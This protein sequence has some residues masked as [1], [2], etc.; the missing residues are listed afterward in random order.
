MRSRK[1]LTISFTIPVP[2]IVSTNDMYFHRPKKSKKGNRITTYTVKTGQLKE[3]QE[4]MDLE[5]KSTLEYYK[6]TIEE[7]RDI[8]SHGYHGLVIV[9]EF[10]MPFENYRDSDTS[11]CIKAYEDCVSRSMGIDDKQNLVYHAEKRCSESDKW[12]VRTIINLVQKDSICL[13]HLDTYCP[14]CLCMTSSIYV[15]GSFENG[16]NSLNM[17]V[18]NKCNNPKLYA[19]DNTITE[20]FNSGFCDVCGYVLIPKGSNEFCSNCHQEYIGRPVSD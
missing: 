3:F 19:S 8:I 4:Y 20:S 14:E 17:I 2:F 11:N 15:R 6:D 5:L 18:C 16:K 13:S 7:M 9:T 12:F 10:H 1:S